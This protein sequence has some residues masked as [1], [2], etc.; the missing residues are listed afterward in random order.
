MVRLCPGGPRRLGPRAQVPNIAHGL[1]CD[2][3]LCSEARCQGV[4]HLSIRLGSKDLDRLRMGTNLDAV[5]PRGD[6][7]GRTRSPYLFRVQFPGRS[8]GTLGLRGQARG[9][10]R[11]FH[12]R[13]SSQLFVPVVDISC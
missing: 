12:H 3:K 1:R 11:A 5:T 7:L 4:A 13:R 2:A 10:A 9:F 6:L 8:G